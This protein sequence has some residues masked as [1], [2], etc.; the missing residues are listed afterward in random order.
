MQTLFVSLNS[1]SHAN[2]YRRTLQCVPL[3]LLSDKF[4]WIGVFDLNTQGKIYVVFKGF[5]W[6]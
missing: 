6:T 3:L 4:K 2:G 5:V 1:F